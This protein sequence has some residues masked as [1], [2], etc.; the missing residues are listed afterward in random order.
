LAQILPERHYARKNLGYLV[1]MARG[2]E[3]IVET[4]DD[5]YPREGFWSERVPSV[6][7]ILAD[8]CGWLNVY[9]YY[10]G[11]HIWP[12]GYPLELVQ[13]P[14]PELDSFPEKKAFCPIQQGLADGNPDVDAVYRLLL[15]LPVHFAIE[16]RIAVGS[17]SWT[18]FN[19]QNTTWFKEAF[20]LLYLP[21][22]CSFRM[23][24]IW[25]SFVASRICWANDWRI[26]FHGPSVWQERNEH[27]LL[28]DFADELDGY[29][30]NASICASLAALEIR[31]GVKNLAENMVT[32]YRTF[33]SQG[34]VGG[35]EMALLEAWLED[36][37][38]G[39]LNI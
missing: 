3:V 12:R 24:D 25:R 28:K 17:G 31:P 38:S 23:C 29:L 26:L 6:R 14:V 18:P 37:S 33:I 7:A 36:V 20:P 32:C 1:A 35:G 13:Q 22:H 2:A 4:D 5:N 8:D 16:P 19:S 9:R 27:N 39:K 15:P 10:S 30:N 11:L 21:S 34:L